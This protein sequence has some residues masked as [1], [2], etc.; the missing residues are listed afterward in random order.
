MSNHRSFIKIAA[1]AIAVS[2]ALPALADTTVSVERGKHHYVYYSDKDIYYAPDTRMYYWVEN[3]RWRSGPSVPLEDQDY[4]VKAKGIDIDLDTDR[5]YERNDYV[6]AHYKNAEPARETTT[7]ERTTTDNGTTTTTT[8]TTT[9]HRY[10]YY[11]DHD[12][13]FAPE[14]HTY[15]WQ[16]NGR[17]ISGNVLPAEDQPYIRSGG[18]TIELDTDRPYER[19]DYVIAHY[20]HR[21]DRDDD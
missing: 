13:F 18:V 5:P 6:V 17:W 14:T 21:H 3:G 15:Y 10:V 16:S 12:I 9:K 1:L 8:T 19:H 4:V 20:K 7:T 11:G 2:A